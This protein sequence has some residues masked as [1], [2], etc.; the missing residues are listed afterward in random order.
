MGDRKGIRCKGEKSRCKIQEEGS[1]YKKYHLPFKVHLMKCKE[2]IDVIL[3]PGQTRNKFCGVEK[4]FWRDNLLKT[5]NHW[6]KKIL[7]TFE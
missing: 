6:T 3:A 4:L 1:V 5:E 2:R 7:I